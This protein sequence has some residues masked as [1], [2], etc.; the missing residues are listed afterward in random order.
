[1][2]FPLFQLLGLPNCFF[3]VVFGK[4]VLYFMSSQRFFRLKSDRSILKCFD[5]ET[6]IIRENVVVLTASSVGNRFLR[7]T[8]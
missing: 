7:A 3:S 2:I 8:T 6:V 1:M 4:A 5:Y